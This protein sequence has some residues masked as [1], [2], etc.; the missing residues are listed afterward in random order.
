MPDPPPET[1]TY[2]EPRDWMKAFI[3]IFKDD[4][5]YGFDNRDDPKQNVFKQYNVVFSLPQS[6]L[7]VPALWISCEGMEGLEKPQSSVDFLYDFRAYID[8]YGVVKKNTEVTYNDMVWVV[9]G[10]Q[11]PE[12]PNNLLF[13]L[14]WYIGRKIEDNPDITDTGIQ[15]NVSHFVSASFFLNGLQNIRDARAVRIG[16]L[17]EVQLT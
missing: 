5:T 1:I 17:L 4:T 16:M 7:Q 15:L 14:M 8:I 12:H 2:L 10:V 9:P 3:A 6:V 13:L 11:H